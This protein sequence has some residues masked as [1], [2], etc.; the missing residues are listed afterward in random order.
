VARRVP[1]VR[2]LDGWGGIVASLPLLNAPTKGQTW[3]DADSGAQWLALTEVKHDEDGVPSV[4]V[5]R[6]DD[7]EAA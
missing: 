7:E 6:I 3:V 1:N 5:Q 4:V 2:L